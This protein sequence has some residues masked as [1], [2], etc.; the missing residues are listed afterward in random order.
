MSK[1]CWWFIFTWIFIVCF[2][3]QRYIWKSCPPFNM[4]TFF[5]VIKPLQWFNSH[6]GFEIRSGQTK[7]YQIN[8]CC[9]SA[10][11]AALRRKNKDW[12]PYR[13]NVFEWGDMSIRGLLFQWASIIQI[14]LSMLVW[15]KS[16]LVIISMKT[17]LFSP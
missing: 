5:K 15:Y 9:L 12:S 10:K 11:H 2:T 17:N 8:I 13:D 14:Q 7:D 6:N 4:S 1:Y 3:F 16:D